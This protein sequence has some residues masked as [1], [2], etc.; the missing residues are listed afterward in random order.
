MDP[1]PVPIALPM[2]PATNTVPGADNDPNS[3]PL[4]CHICPKKPTFSDVSHLLT[5]I[6]SKSHL[7]ARFKLQLS[8]VA[9]HKQALH[10]FDEWAE[11]YGI[12]RLL[13]NRQDAKEQ[14]KQSHLKRQRGGNE[15]SKFTPLQSPWPLLTTSHENRRN[16]VDPM[17]LVQR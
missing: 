6:S 7:A 10:R 16:P 17:D 3:I 5:H 8:D 11:N 15:V 1:I 13:K 4:L 12:N 2:E 9:S 14:K